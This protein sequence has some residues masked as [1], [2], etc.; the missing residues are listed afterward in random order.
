MSKV[1]QSTRER[2]RLVKTVRGFDIRTMVE[3]PEALMLCKTL[4]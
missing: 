4:P 3:T 2:E 1:V